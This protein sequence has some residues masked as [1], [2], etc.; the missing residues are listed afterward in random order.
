MADVATE[1]GT[2]MT[3][4]VVSI[5]EINNSADLADTLDGQ[6]GVVWGLIAAHS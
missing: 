1:G 6:I 2:F 4:K 5:C 3:T